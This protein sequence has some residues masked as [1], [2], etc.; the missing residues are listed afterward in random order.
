M[1]EHFTSN[2]CNRWNACVE[3]VYLN[4]MDVGLSPMDGRDVREEDGWSLRL[5]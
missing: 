1:S 3:T 4:G 2:G 5:N